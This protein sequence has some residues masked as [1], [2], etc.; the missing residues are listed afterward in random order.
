MSAAANVSSNFFMS[1]GRSVR[2]NLSAILS[3][4]G[5]LFGCRG[6]SDQPQRMSVG[7]TQDSLPGVLAVRKIFCPAAVQVLLQRIQTVY[8]QPRLPENQVVRLC[9][10]GQQSSSGRRDVFKKFN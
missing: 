6:N 5:N 10:V 2:E 4:E 7:I 3:S 8:A 1:V 9:V